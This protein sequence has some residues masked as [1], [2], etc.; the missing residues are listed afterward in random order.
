MTVIFRRILVTFLLTTWSAVTWADLPLTVEDLLTA[1]DRYRLEF[2]LNYANSDRKNVDSIFDL[3]QIAPGS[4]LLLPVAIGEERRN[5]DFLAMTLGFRY[6]LST[7]TELFTRLTASASDVRIQNNTGA[8]SRAS[9]QI[10]NVVIGVNYKF[11]NDNDTPA[12]LG[13]AEMIVAENTATDDTNFIHAKSG[14]IGFTTYRTIDPLV[15]SLTSGYRYAG[16]R[17]VEE[18]S[19]D[20]GDLLFINPRVGFAVN[21]LVTLRGGIQLKF[22]GRDKIAGNAV[23]IRTTATD[24]MFGLGYA[25]SKR[26]TMNFTARANISGDAG[27][28]LGFTLLYKFGDLPVEN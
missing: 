4:F 9:Q 26:M 19:I 20:P 5:T 27:A 23:S 14:Q 18:L 6:G 10:K 12:L 22:R 17:D 8:G 21:N 15:L 2:S 3:V 1:Q 28:Q 13:F 11:S 7:D 25:A 24:L 16:R